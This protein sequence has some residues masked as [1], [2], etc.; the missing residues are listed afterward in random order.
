MDRSGEICKLF[1]KIFYLAQRI[2]IV[3]CT[4]LV[5]VWNIL[6]KAAISLVGLP[7]VKDIHA[8]AVAL[9]LFCQI[10][11]RWVCSKRRSCSIPFALGEIDFFLFVSFL[12][13]VEFIAGSQYEKEDKSGKYH[14]EAENIDRL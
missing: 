3:R 11:F 8:E 4:R 10:Y 1:Y 5:T 13:P 6:I 9:V 12:R 2:F 7:A 14:E